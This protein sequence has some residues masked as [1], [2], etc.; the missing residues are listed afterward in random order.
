M[1]R[2]LQGRYPG[3]RYVCLWDGDGD[4]ELSFDAHP[5]WRSGNRIEADV[6]PTDQGMM[7]RIL[8]TNPA[9]PVRNVR[10]IMPGFEAT[11][12]A[13]PFH[14]LFLHNWR[15]FRVLRFMDWA[16]T[17]GSTQVAWSDRCTPA[18]FS[19]ATDR[20]VAFEHM[21]DLCNELDADAWF[22]LPHLCD[23]DYARQLARLV[24][25]RLEAGRAVHVE[26]SNECWHTDFAGGRFCRD[27]G[28]RLGLSSVPH[29]AQL[30]FYSERAVARL[31][32]FGQELGGSHRLVRVLAAQNANPWTGTQMLD[33][34]GAAAEV[35]ALAVAPYFGYALGDPGRQWEVV[36]M[37]VNQVLAECWMDLGV[38]LF[39]TYGHAVNAHQRGVRLLGYEGGQHL[40][41]WG[42]AENNPALTDLFVAANRRVEMA[43]LY[44]LFLE[45]W[46]AIGGGDLAMYASSIRP[47]KFGSWGLLESADQDPFT[48]P[49]YIAVK[50]WHLGYRLF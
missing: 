13:R 48:A 44:L 35:D 4:I 15:G 41:G 42:G 26:Y 14:P 2:G 34:R 46:R 50:A 43:W 1:M 29:E 32:T 25:Q 24:R 22:C 6:W 5:Q 31:R 30:R 49:K 33:W 18:W 11:Y 47:G 45:G 40:V 7:L 27:E 17:N 12:A 28:L 10:M 23:D 16:R 8:R 39:G 3:G 19:Q 21:I 36:Q 20:G 9:D 37:S 38:T